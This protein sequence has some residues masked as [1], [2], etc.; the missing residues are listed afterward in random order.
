MS[1]RDFSRRAF[2]QGSVVA[3]IG[4]S[5]VPLGSRAFAAL[6]EE[7]VT[8]NPKPW[9]GSA[10]QA[11]GRIDGVSK[12]CGAKVFARDIRAQDMPGWPQRQGHALLLKA[13]KADQL[14][15]GLDLSMLSD[16]LA[17][18]RVVTA[19]D[20][21][22]DGIAWPE[23]HGPDPFLPE[24]QVP[25]FL[26][27]PVAMLIWH[28][29]ERYR[30][31][32]KLLKFNDQVI[33]Y[34]A[35]A[36]PYSR[37][38][39]GS[40]RFVRVAADD[41]F[42]ADEFSSLKNT[43]LFPMI[44]DKKPSWSQGAKLDGDLTQQGL[45]HAERMQEQLASPPDDWLVFDERY[46]TQSIEPAA[47]EP[48]NGN[49][50]F[51]AA[52]GTLHFV[53]A[54]QCP[55][56]V[57]EQCAHML[58]PS[59]FAVQAL[60]MHPGYTVGYGSKD[61]NIFVFYAALAALYGEGVPV[62]LANDRYEQFQSG[63]KRHPFD[64]HYQLAVSK[65]D[66]RFHIFRAHMDVDGGGRINYSPSVAAVGAT[67]AQSIYYMPRSDLAATAYHSRGVEA[68]SMRGYGTLQ[69]M[70]ATEMMVDEVAER[71]GVDAIELRLKNA[72]QSGMK[73]TQGAIPAG[74]LRLDE[75]LHK[76][77][78]HPVWKE[79]VARKARFDAEDPDN[80]YGVGFA[81]CQKDFGTGAEAPMASVEFDAEGR[82]SL[83]QIAIDM[84]TGMSTSQALL[85][86]DWLGHPADEIKTGVTEWAELALI[87]SGNPYITSPAEQDAALKN[88]RW[89]ARIASPSSATNSAYYS[90]HA[91]REAA[92]LLFNH[93]LWPAALNLWGQ[94]IQGGLANPY[95]VRR[96]EAHWVEGKLTASGMPPIAFAVLARKAHEL[97][98]VTGASVHG[99]NRWSW[100]D[101]EFDIDGSRERV[102]LDAVAL[103]YGNGASEEKKARI[104]SH[105]FH[106]L[107]RLNVHYPD[108][109][110][111]NAMV[112]Y[113]SPV[114][115]LV[116]VKVNKGSGAAQVLSHHSWLECG[117]TIVPE[118]VLGQ[119]EGGIAMGIGHAL[120]EEMPK[121]EGGPGEGQWNFNRYVLPRAKDV[122]VWA[123]S[124]EILPPLSPSDPPK[125]I[126]EVVM[127]PVVGAIV[128]AVAH[129]TGKRLRDLP[130]TPARI[131]EALHG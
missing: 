76:A 39:Y 1:N 36:E 93:G 72:M 86:A 83:R 102:P 15:A 100:A 89:V 95:V 77:A 23:S 30:Q 103:K 115:T 78:E 79:R 37:D 61:N 62:R 119:L 42:A 12:A 112:T 64:M 84:G 3:G 25:M 121:Y 49:G 80:Y 9:Y 101:A 47:L 16:E 120:L 27:H 8:A 44:R 41:P 85:V 6:F 124:G 46:T 38:P 91:T 2:L 5:L 54:T 24:G 43:M 128:N 123:Q 106:L 74:A 126:A 71:L 69:T 70:A 50:W 31:A 122:A 117:R 125:G 82:I 21:A 109:Q 73:N 52:S 19:V 32:K 35:K 10:G 116:E 11:R 34:G 114:A 56:E 111:N 127:I 130:L 17:P 7:Q 40:F 33:R 92:R 58:A 105:G 104:N 53:V 65:Q 63:I 108:T 48:D 22:R 81:I 28:D 45:Y 113:Y 98:L 129:A 18:D 110:L 55:F 66:Q 90:S 99:F 13:T 96:E 57:A 88:P 51:D 131:K 14:Y 107:D 67:A 94:G 75:I 26:G 87:T 97:G 118:L 29:F 60:T 4:I 68:G 59:K 20:L